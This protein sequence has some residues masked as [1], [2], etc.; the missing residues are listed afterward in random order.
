[1]YFWSQ[2]I[3]YACFYVNCHVRMYMIIQQH[4]L[5]TELHKKYVYIYVCHCL[6]VRERKCVCV[7]VCVCVYLACFIPSL[8]VACWSAH[9]I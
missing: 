3:S 1:M 8:V 5:S 9:S 6:C 2:L 4:V 7:Y